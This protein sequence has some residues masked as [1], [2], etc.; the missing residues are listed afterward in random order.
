MSG[1]PLNYQFGLVGN[2]ILQDDLVNG[3]HYWIKENGAY[4]IWYTDRTTNAWMVGSIGNL[5]TYFFSYL[6]ISFWKKILWHF[7][8]ILGTSV[9]GLGS[10]CTKEC[11]YCCDGKKYNIKKF[12]IC[13][14]R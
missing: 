8:T 9:G 13:L 10:R 4:G 5:G 3:K 7:G 6:P 12:V 14:L 1:D 11:G 2:Y